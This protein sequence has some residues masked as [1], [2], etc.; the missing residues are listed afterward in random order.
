M[1]SP[2]SLRQSLAEQSRHSRGSDTRTS[3]TEIRDRNPKTT[4]KTSPC[5]SH[6][7]LPKT[8][9]PAQ[10]I[11]VYTMTIPASPRGLALSENAFSDQAKAKNSMT[12]GQMPQ[13]CGYLNPRCSDCSGH[14]NSKRL[15][16]QVNII[17]Q[18][19]INAHRLPK[20]A[21][22]NPIPT[23]QITQK[24]VGAKLSTA[25]VVPNSAVAT[26]NHN[27]K[28]DNIF[29]GHRNGHSTQPQATGTETS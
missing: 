25:L 1:Q 13:R 21:T 14:T 17:F 3:V 12:A 26:T 28:Q 18:G 4:E 16:D 5:L 9:I 29:A 15:S 6:C 27:S 11:I 20:R 24:K 8:N 23:H 22:K 2:S 19:L 7:C 10:V